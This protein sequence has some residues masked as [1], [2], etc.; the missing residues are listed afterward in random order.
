[1]ARYR[2]SLL[3]RFVRWCLG[4]GGALVLFFSCVAAFLVF[5]PSSPLPDALNPTKPL[6]PSASP[7]L[8]TD[9]KLRR[10][11][12][13]PE[14]CLA[15]LNTLQARLQKLPDRRV[16][17]QCGIPMRVNVRKLASANLNGLET[18]CP[19]ALRLAMWD[20]HVVQPAAQARFGTSVR[21]MADFGSFS[22]RPIRNSSGTSRRMSQHATA[23][24]VDIAGF[25]LGDG[26]RIS[27]LKDWN[28]PKKGAFLKE[29][30]DGACNWF[31]V[32]LSPDYN[33]LH[34]DH[35]HFDMGRWRSCR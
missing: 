22:C 28:D 2:E 5:W 23:N 19:I 27:L 17:A 24:A 8:M 14:Q 4:L 15:A 9:W 32:T 26:R 33:A 3:F 18:A 12:R 34:A 21:A 6:V 10:A 30:R 13:T 25:T 7:N 35:F 11:S 1:M 29:V 20:Y 16:S 31:N